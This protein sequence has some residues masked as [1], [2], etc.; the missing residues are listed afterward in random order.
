[1]YLSRDEVETASQIQLHHIHKNT[2]YSSKIDSNLQ[3]DIWSLNKKLIEELN[4][5]KDLKVLNSINEKYL[6]YFEEL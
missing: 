5:S 1:V 2:H 6:G 4:E 3:R